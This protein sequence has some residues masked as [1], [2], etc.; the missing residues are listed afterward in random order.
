LSLC[1]FQ[2]QIPQDII[3]ECRDRICAILEE[4]RIG[5][6]LRMQDFDNYMTLMNGVVSYYIGY[7][8]N[9]SPQLLQDI[10]EIERFMEKRPSFAEYCAFIRRYKDM[11]DQVAREIYGVLSMGFYE[12]H[13]EGLIDTLESLAKFM[14]NELIAKM[15]ADQQRDALR[16]ANDYE[17]ISTKILTVPKDTAELMALK[18]YAIKME[19]STIPEMED[20]LRLV[21]FRRGVQLTILS[22]IFCTLEPEPSPLSDRLH[23]LHATGD[24]T[25]Q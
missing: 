22:H 9:Y 23:A 2:P 4:Q 1:P 15:V 19:T 16:L 3:A 20:K 24:Q 25:E 10:D 13:R 5:P 6:E 17:A 12:F 11:E 8:V 18:G 14:Q 7:A 21:S